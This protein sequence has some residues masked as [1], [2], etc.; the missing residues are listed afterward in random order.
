MNLYRMIQSAVAKIQ[1]VSKETIWSGKWNGTVFRISRRVPN[2]Y[3]WNYVYSFTASIITS[4]DGA[5]DVCMCLSLPL[6]KTAKQWQRRNE[7][8][9]HQ[10][11][12]LQTRREGRTRLREA[13]ATVLPPPHVGRSRCVLHI[14]GGVEVLK[15]VHVNPP[16]STR[17]LTHETGLSQSAV[18]RTP[19]HT[20]A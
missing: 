5:L 12:F 11:R 6:R 20:I 9:W 18:L 7:M 2:F 17:R 14:R 3:S 13:G 16:T 1:V 8:A 19:H 15:A 10:L 4:R